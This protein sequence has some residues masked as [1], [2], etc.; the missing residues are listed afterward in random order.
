MPSHAALRPS[1]AARACVGAPVICERDDPETQPPSQ[2]ERASGERATARH[3]Q[4]ELLAEWFGGRRAA[5]SRRTMHVVLLPVCALA[6]MPRGAVRVKAKQVVGRHRL[7]LALSARQHRQRRRR[8]RRRVGGGGRRARSRCAVAAG[9][10]L[11]LR[12]RA[13]SAVSRVCRA[14]GPATAPATSLAVPRRTLT[15]V[16]RTRRAA[17]PRPRRNRVQACE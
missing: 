5:W 4:I 1:I 2:S 7:A 12:A 11:R 8:Q 16:A 6:G 15:R 14:A 9:P 13:S 10:R 3:L 17:Q